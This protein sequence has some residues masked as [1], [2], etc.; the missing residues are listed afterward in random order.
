MDPNALAGGGNV[1]INSIKVSELCTI[2]SQGGD[3][4]IGG[5]D[6]VA[7]VDSSGGAVQVGRM[8]QR[9]QHPSLRFG[10]LTR[11]PFPTL[12]LSCSEERL[13]LSQGV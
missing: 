6:G 2:S 12:C 13:E 11:R 8:G 7:A 1:S 5:A 4:S 9:R 3:I 10:S